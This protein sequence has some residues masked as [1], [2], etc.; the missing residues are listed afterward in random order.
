M[1]GLQGGE[2]KFKEGDRVRV[3]TNDSHKGE[4]GTVAMASELYSQAGFPYNVHFNNGDELI[5]K[6][7]E[8]IKEEYMFNVGDIVKSKNGSKRK[9]LAV[10][11]ELTALS[12]SD[13][14]DYFSNLWFTKEEIKE[15][16]YELAKEDEK[17]V[18]MQEIADKFGV[19]VDS[20]KVEK[21]E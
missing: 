20:L 18:T 13:T 3:I 4:I 21:G 14:Y 12:N 8:L 9:V 15:Y 17:V 5:Y 1:L 10:C 16:I 19:D 7:K 6:D 2:M 11:G